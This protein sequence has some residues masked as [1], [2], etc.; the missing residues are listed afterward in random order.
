[1]DKPFV[2]IIIV[3]F[4]GAIYLPA[5]LDA[6]ETQTYPSERFEVIVSDNNSTDISIDLIEKEYP[7]VKIIKN[8]QNLGFAEG[9]NVAIRQSENDYV[10]FL[11]NDTVPAKTWLS[12][13][14]KLAESGPDIGIVTGHLQL[15]YPQLMIDIGIDIPAGSEL[16][17]V[18]D[19]DT[20]AFKGVVQYLEGFSSP[21]AD[22]T[23]RNFRWVSDRAS[24]GI[25]I[26]F[27]QDEW[28]LKLRVA[29]NKSVEIRISAGEV[30]LGRLQ[31]DGSDA[32]DYII[33]I[34][35]EVQRD[36][37]SVEQNTGSIVFSNGSGRDRGTYV[38]GTEVYYEIDH[39]QYNQIEEV[40]AG[41]GASL[42]LRRSMLDEIGLLDSSFFMYYEDTDLSWRARLAGWKV[43]YS[44]T[45]KC[46]HIHCGTTS[47]WSPKFL[48]MTE[49]NRLAMVFKN[50]S[51]RQ[52]IRVWGRYFLHELKLGYNTFRSLAR[53]EA[54]WR[55]QVHSLFVNLK[56]LGIL[57][58]WFPILCVKR[59]RI[60]SQAKVKPSD[61]ET[62]FVE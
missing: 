38:K 34:P 55:S 26:P 39:G 47:E 50:G 57:T 60:H 8:N 59:F 49:R 56:V 54:G 35:K 2:T 11:N 29:V 61:L 13:M 7:W 15:Y 37:F 44:P 31:V 27:M 28:K 30:Q 53:R 40:F 45:A 5:C 17:R 41:C 25:P 3:N 10:I 58:L 20:A 51:L 4:N 36:F 14:V 42:L 6:L 21:R 18:Y 22:E 12:E 23:G 48:F 19:V 16:V 52:I 32:M 46:A 62:W 9:N 43:L 33:E 24:L 1:M